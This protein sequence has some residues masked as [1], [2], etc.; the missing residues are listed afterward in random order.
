M[1]N[2]LLIAALMLCGISIAHTQE[3]SLGPTL[4]INHAWIS[5]APGDTRGLIGLNAGLTM[6]YSTEEHWGLGLDLKYSGEGMMTEQ[7]GITAKTRL[8]Y[9]R[10]PL[11]VYYFF[12]NFEDDFRPKIYAGPSLG[13][14]VGGQTEQFSEIG[15]IE[16]DSKDFYEDFDLGLL[17]GTGFNYR[18]AERT[19]FNFDLAYAH[20]LTDIAKTGKGYNRNLNL[21]VGIAWGF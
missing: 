20:G 11:K 10:V 9:V 14:L 5:D 19:W 16:L 2:P 6:V 18:L 12:N 4:G 17:L 1:K 3:F 7:R 15:T 8:D 21:N 13:F